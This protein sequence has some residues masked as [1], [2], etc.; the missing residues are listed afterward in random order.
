[1][2]L[3]T[4]VASLENTTQAMWDVLLDTESSHFSQ[5][6]FNIDASLEAS[7]QDAEPC[8][9]TSSAVFELSDSDQEREFLLHHLDIAPAEAQGAIR[10]QLQDA[11]K[12]ASVRNKI[13]KKQRN[14][15]R[16]AMLKQRKFHLL[17]PPSPVQM[18][19]LCQH[20]VVDH[21]PLRREEISD[22]G[23]TTLHNWPA[24]CPLISSIRS[25]VSCSELDFA[26]Y[27]QHAARK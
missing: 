22:W 26:L 20:Q 23:H 2:Q 6:P 4:R 5:D 11:R 19:L 12:R 21:L 16:S 3:K 9:G 24:P 17:L 25:V 14:S 10:K 1:M 18:G 27:S 8:S 7:H 15:L 13:K